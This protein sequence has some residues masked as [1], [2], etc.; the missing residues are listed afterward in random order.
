MPSKLHITVS[1]ALHCSVALVILGGVPAIW[2]EDGPP[3]S[4]NTEEPNRADELTEVDGE[5]VYAVPAMAAAIHTPAMGKTNDEQNGSSP[6]QIE[7]AGSPASVEA[8]QPVAPTEHLTPMIDLR[9]EQEVVQDSGQ[10][11][12]NQPVEAEVAHE[13]ILNKDTGNPSQTKDNDATIAIIKNAQETEPIQTADRTSGSRVDAQSLASTN[14]IPV[15]LAPADV[16]N[17]DGLRAPSFVVI[18]LD[19]LQMDQ[20]VR[21]KQGV[22][23]A[24]CAGKY[25]ALR[26]SL[27]EPASLN[28]VS[29]S[30]LTGFSRRALPVPSTRYHKTADNLRWSYSFSENDLKKLQV[31]LFF[32][33]A[34]DTLILQRQHQAAHRLAVQLEDIEQTWGLFV[35]SQER[36]VD[37]QIT[38]L[39]FQDGRTLQVVKNDVGRTE[40]RS[41]PSRTERE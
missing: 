34:L 18:G 6:G 21:A 31:R 5:L 41:A 39:V 40:N 11:S 20:I 27:E 7:Y 12:D 28:P 35:F 2:W 8:T 30:D 33:N 4:E 13:Q 19:R 38:S 1:I 26:E 24:L 15:R 29:A 36:V 23:V 32:V 37:F 14:A 17:P 22:Y 3:Q 16:L 25:F 9:S 10:V